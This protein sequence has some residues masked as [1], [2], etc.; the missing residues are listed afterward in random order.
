MDIAD[1]IV[2]AGAF[3]G[4]LLSQP[5]NAYVLRPLGNRRTHK[6]LMERTAFRSE[7]GRNPIS[8]FIRHGG[9]GRG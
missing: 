5:F 1:L 4:A 8:F 3:V 9:F 6:R 7:W 2:L